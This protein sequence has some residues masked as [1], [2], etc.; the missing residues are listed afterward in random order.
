M[1][2]GDESVNPDLLYADD[3][4]LDNHSAEDMSIHMEHI[5]ASSKVFGSWTSVVMSQPMPGK[6][7]GNPSVLPE[8][9]ELKHSRQVVDKICRSSS[10]KQRNNNNE[11]NDNNTNDNNTNDTVPSR[12]QFH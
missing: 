12:Q 6:P 11:N 1:K 7:Y 5:P 3:C 10:T 8:E 4:G 2:N 9:T